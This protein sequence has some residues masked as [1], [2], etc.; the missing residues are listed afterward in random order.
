MDTKVN[1]EPRVPREAVGGIL[2]GLVAAALLWLAVSVPVGLYRSSRD[3]HWCTE[4]G[5][6]GRQC[7]QERRAERWG[8]FDAWGPNGED[9]GT[10][11][12]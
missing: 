4:F 3:D 8:P 6:P 12:D 1:R 10:G 7:V 2:A 5:H 9:R 11:G